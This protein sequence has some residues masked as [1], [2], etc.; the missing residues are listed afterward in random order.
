MVD[1]PNFNYANWTL[2][3]KHAWLTGGQGAQAAA[4][5]PAREV[6]AFAGRVAQSSENLRR[7]LG[8]TG[9]E[10]RGQTATVVAA[11]MHRSADWAA[12]AGQVTGQGGGQVDGYGASFT[13][14]AGKVSAPGVTGSFWDYA[15]EIFALPDYQDRLAKDAEADANANLALK[16][17]ENTA[18]TN[19]TGF[20]DP[21]GAQPMP[22]GGGATVR[23][24]RAGGRVGGPGGGGG[25][26]VPAGGAATPG[27]SGSGLGAG[28]SGGTGMDAGGTGMDAGGTA[29]SGGGAGGGAA[30][31]LGGH[32]GA[33]A[34]PHRPAG[35]PRP[36]P[37][38]R[39]MREPR[40]ASP[41]AGHR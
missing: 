29:G 12:S 23:G 13:S 31:G 24:S 37:A 41:R 8:G 39:A 20:R 4:N 15:Q 26:G 36:P 10:W 38:R 21:A 16:N 11:S 32:S 28:G 35:S 2:A 7:A 6:N 34:P 40:A 25:A 33:A 1:I 17:H 22:Q 18:R 27:G 19:L 14:L 30:A 9:V 3:Q 5:D